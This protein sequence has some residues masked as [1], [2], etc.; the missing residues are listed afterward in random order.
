MLLFHNVYVLDSMATALESW[1]GRIRRTASEGLH[2]SK[3]PLLR[4]HNEL[5][6]F[7]IQ[8]YAASI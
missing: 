7:H 6:P 3:L 4:A 1:L 2:L 8:T 5:F